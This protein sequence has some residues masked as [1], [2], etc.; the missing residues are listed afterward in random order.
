MQI[1]F[2]PTTKNDLKWYR[3]YYQTVFPEGVV[4]AQTQFLACK[5]MLQANPFIGH[6]SEDIAGARELHVARTPFTIVYRVT[7]VRIEILR[8]W[9]TRQGG[10]L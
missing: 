5:Q 10:A 9:D 6:T 2:L 1:V 3:Q 8:I 4:R 7:D